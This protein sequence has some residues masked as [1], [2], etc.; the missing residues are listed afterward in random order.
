MCFG[1]GLPLALAL[2]AY[3]PLLLDAL[4]L[5]ASSAVERWFFM[6]EQKSPFLAIGIA[7][8][9]LWRRRRALLSLPDRTAPALAA[10]LLGLGVGLFA[11]ARLT[12]EAFLLLPSLAANWLAFASAAKGRVGC[13]AGLLPA[14]VLLLGVPIPAPLRDEL[15]WRL[16]L[17]SARSAT[18]L[19]QAGGAEVAL[20]GVQVQS[21]EFAFTVIESCSGLRGIEILTAVAVAI[22]ELLAVPGWR[23]WLVVLV[24]PWLG[25]VLNVVRIVAV[26]AMASSAGP[27]GRAP[28]NWDHT[29][30]GV[31]V[32]V[33]GTLL[34]YAFGR[35]LAGSAQ[36]P[37]PEQAQRS[38]APGPG[39]LSLRVGAVAMA[40]LAS[41]AAVSVAVAP[42]PRAQEPPAIELPGQQA[43]WSGTDLPLDRVFAG[44]FQPGQVLYRRY[45][46]ERRSGPPRIVDV[47]IGREVTGNPAGHLF[48]PKLAL[49][50]HDWS[51]RDSRRTR[52]WDLG[53]DADL[54]VASRGSDLVLAYRWQLRDQGIL[55]ETWRSL[56]ALEVGP[57]HRERGRAVVRLS[58]P[59]RRDGPVLRDRSKKALDLFI[60]DF[61]DELA[62]L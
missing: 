55:R 58:T 53:P 10:L 14:L 39:S 24:A 16:Q 37:E 43:G 1:A 41:L 29:P 19:L 2:F 17:W 11:W 22:R 48:S 8:W 60:R 25:F 42:F 13:R 54:A 7:G 3:R 36:Q 6:P 9:L 40:A 5:P 26:V 51:L 18:W 38:V 46:S 62:G 31:A 23:P 61:G 27:E 44:Q 49:P 52:L 12:G 33:A 30:Q 35:W 34:L 50:G 15:L 57:F 4:Q 47:L 32:L 28:E 20:R 21:G 59:L 45:Q 56:L